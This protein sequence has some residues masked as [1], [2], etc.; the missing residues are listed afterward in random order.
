VTSIGSVGPSGEPHP[1]ADRWAPQVRP[2]REKEK[3]P[4]GFWA[5]FQVGRLGRPNKARLGSWISLACGSAGRLGQWAGWACRLA[6]LKFLHRPAFFLPLLSVK[7]H[8]RAATGNTR[9]R[10][11]SGTAGGPRSLGQRPSD[12]AYTLAWSR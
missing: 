10:E 5:Q 11:A 7:T 2:R 3:G 1:E 6:R 8:R 9:S 12:L 4:G